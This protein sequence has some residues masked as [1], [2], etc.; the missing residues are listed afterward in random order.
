VD[1]VPASVRTETEVE[2]T[3]LVNVLAGSLIVVASF[4]VT[5]LVIVWTSPGTVEKAV[6]VAKDVD[7][8]VEVAGLRVVACRPALV[9]VIVAQTVEPGRNTVEV[10]V[11]DVMV[12]FTVSV[13]VPAARA[14]SP[15]RSM[16]APLEGA[17]V[18]VVF[19]VEVWVDVVEKTVVL[20]LGV[21]VLSTR[22]P[23]SEIVLVLLTPFFVLVMYEVCTEP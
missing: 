13:V 11:K 7:R 10:L 2:R 12:W 19:F 3:M 20:G 21:T 23:E 16:R 6:D 1:V 8:I 22:A 15:L 18:T 4:F 14:S 9:L 5:R 17:Q